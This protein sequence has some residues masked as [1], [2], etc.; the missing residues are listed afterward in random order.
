MSLIIR[1]AKTNTFYSKE[2]EKLSREKYWSI[3]K[4]KYLV[5]R[6]WLLSVLFHKSSLKFI[7]YSLARFPVGLGPLWAGIL[8]ETPISGLFVCLDG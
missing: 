8:E 7:Y 6:I 5:N 3:G 1:I 4:L 2:V